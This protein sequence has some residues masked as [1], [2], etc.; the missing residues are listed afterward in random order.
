MQWMVGLLSRQFCFVTTTVPFRLVTKTV[1]DYFEH[2]SVK[3]QQ[4]PPNDIIFF[5]VSAAMMVDFWLQSFRKPRCSSTQPQLNLV[6]FLFL[7]SVLKS[8]MPFASC[9]QLQF[10]DGVT[11]EAVKAF[12]SLGSFQILVLIQI[13][14]SRELKQRFHIDP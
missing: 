2:S 12:C 7:G 5:H 3:I 13:L 11:K 14:C 8:K 9:P 4:H 10:A 1:M 6:F